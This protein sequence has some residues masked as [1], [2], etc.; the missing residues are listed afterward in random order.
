[1]I[2]TRSTEDNR[3]DNTLIV[4]V[5][6]HV[7]NPEYKELSHELISLDFTSPLLQNMFEIGNNDRKWLVVFWET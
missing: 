3:Y 1:M 2:V 7:I 5:K 6:F 4:E